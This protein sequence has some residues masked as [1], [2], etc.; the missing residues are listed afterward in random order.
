MNTSPMFLSLMAL[1]AC[2]GMACTTT[3]VTAPPADPAVLFQQASDAREQNQK[4]DAARLYQE[5]IRAVE[6]VPAIEDHAMA[7]MEVAGFF[8]EIDPP[9]ALKLYAAL[10]QAAEER[11]DNNVVGYTEIR[12]DLQCA[13]GETDAAVAS[14]RDSIARQEK[15]WGKSHPEIANSHRSRSR[16]LIDAGRVKAGFAELDAML[17]I[18]IQVHGESAMVAP[19]IAEVAHQK[20]EL[21][22]IEAAQ[23]DLDWAI[24]L[25]DAAPDN[26]HPIQKD[27]LKTLRAQLQQD[28]DS[29]TP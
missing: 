11:N 16:C 21:G 19:A 15:I 26:L 6:G 22:H 7:V 12:G 2:L 27:I 23:A 8:E 25:I 14:Y 4:E 18:R 17:K 13:I 24:R 29:L 5:W 10:I 20:A 28:R 3:S 1:L 9:T